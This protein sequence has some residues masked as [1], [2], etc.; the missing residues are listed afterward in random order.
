MPHSCCWSVPF[1]SCIYTAVPRG[2]SL[3]SAY[4]TAV[5]PQVQ[6]SFDYEHFTAAHRQTSRLIVHFLCVLMPCMIRSMYLPLCTYKLRTMCI[7]TSYYRYALV[8]SVVPGLRVFRNED[9][10]LRVFQNEDRRLRVFQNE[11][12]RH[13]CI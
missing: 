7:L 12:R 6:S 10:R 8:D 11:D 3:S 5:G 13:N 9:R 4:L 2:W 1:C